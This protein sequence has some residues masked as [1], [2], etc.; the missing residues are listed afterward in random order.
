MGNQDWYGWCVL[1]LAML[2]IGTQARDI[3]RP[4]GSRDHTE[5][6]VGVP[7]GTY[8]LE[9]Y[10]CSKPEDAM[11]HNI[12]QSCPTEKEGASTAKLSQTPQ[13]NYTI[14]QEVVTFDYPPTLCTVHR[15]RGYYDCV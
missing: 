15:S 7:R 6:G 4:Q 5:E 9:A 3:S 1:M 2:A 12:P 11:V 10:D 8:R 14:L 13:Q